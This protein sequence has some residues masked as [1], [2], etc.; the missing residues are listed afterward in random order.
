MND[1]KSPF[2]ILAEDIFANHD[3]VE[4]AWI[5]DREVRCIAS[6]VSVDPGYTEFG[7]D[8][9]ASFFLRVPAAEF[10]KCDE[11]N[12]MFR[13]QSYKIASRETDSSG[14]TVN[15]YLASRGETK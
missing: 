9:G 14:R 8:E 7:F 6:A 10:A 5:G 4:P 12:V 13:G 1:R 15:L 2:D 11:R 3:F